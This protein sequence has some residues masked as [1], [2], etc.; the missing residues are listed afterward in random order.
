[1]LSSFTP[2][3]YNIPSTYK[4]AGQLLSLP[5]IKCTCSITSHFSSARFAS[6]P[7]MKCGGS[8]RCTVDRTCLMNK[9]RRATSA[10]QQLDI[11]E[12]MKDENRFFTRL[13]NSQNGD[14]HD[15]P[16]TSGALCTRCK[17]FYLQKFGSMLYCYKILCDGDLA[18]MIPIH[19][20]LFENEKFIAAQFKNKCSHP[21]SN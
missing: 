15:D 9:F 6:L 21:K 4:E 19:S 20:E 16:I 2:L 13:W 3:P 11:L 12:I 10:Q 14:S 1:M 17:P 5:P 18:R 7:E 8:K